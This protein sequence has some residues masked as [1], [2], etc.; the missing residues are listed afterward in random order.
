MEILA[1]QNADQVSA[2]EKQHDFRKHIPLEP[3]RG[4]KT[5]SVEDKA[6]QTNAEA[7]NPN[8]N[9]SDLQ[10]EQNC[11]AAEGRTQHNRTHKQL[12]QQKV[13]RRRTRVVS[14]LTKRH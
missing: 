1:S 9:T 11:F 2:A 6:K 4:T 7:Q 13:D 8:L 10:R 12:K 14:T 3:V 5:D